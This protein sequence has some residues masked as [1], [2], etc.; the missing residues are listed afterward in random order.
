[1]PTFFFA[2]TVI[3][4]PQQYIERYKEI[5]LEQMYEFNIPASVILA[6]AIFESNMG[7]S[8][9]A[10]KSNNHFGIKCH[11][12]WGGDTAVVHDDTY[13]ECFRKYTSIELSY[14]DHSLFLKS[15]GN[16]ANLFSLNIHDY[17]T[18][19]RGLKASGY[20]TYPYYDV[21]L[22]KIIEENELYKLERP[23]QLKE[24]I[25]ITTQ[26]EIKTTV[27]S[28]NKF[29]DYENINFDLL[30]SNEN[31]IPTQIINFICVAN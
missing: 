9:L 21:V 16:Y 17:K 14:L 30:F 20:A 31:D 7:N 24:A 27:K 6:Q 28:S 23:E 8:N 11:I 12:E 5:A 19:C 29:S 3:S 2:Q 25:A 26:H 1:M 13:N 4:S 18:W 10:K 15:R 22:I